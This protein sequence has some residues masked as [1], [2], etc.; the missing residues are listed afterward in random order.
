MTPA[1]VF[2]L[3]LA[4]CWEGPPGELADSTADAS[5][6]ATEPIESDADL[7]TTADTEEAPE[8]FDFDGQRMWDDVNE[9][10]SEAYAGRMPGT[11][12]GELAL[13]F[14]EQHFAAMGLTPLGMNGFRKTFPFDMWLQQGPSV[15]EVE[16]G[17]W[18]EKQDFGLLMGSGAGQVEAALVFAGYGLTVPAFDAASYPTCPL[19]AEGYDDYAGLDVEGKIV[20]V[21]RHGPGGDDAVHEGCPA[22]AAAK[23]FTKAL[24]S[25]GY[26]A[27][28]AALHGAAAVLIVNRFGTPESTPIQGTVGPEYHDPQ[29]IVASVHRQKVA[30]ALPE[31][32][33]WQA[34]IDKNLAPASTDTGLQLVLEAQAGVEARETDNL[35]A[36]FPGTDPELSKEAVV[37]GAHIDHLGVDPVTGELYA[38]ADDNA[39]G[40]SVLMELAR[41]LRAGLIEPRR[42]VVLA[43]FNAEEQGLLGSCEYVRRPSH[44]IASTKAMF[45]LDMVG[46]GDG[47]G[48]VLYGADGKTFPE[49][50]DL[51]RSSAEASGVVG[52]VVQGPALDASDHYCFALAGVP[53]VLVSSSGLHKTYHTPK[54]TADAILPSVLETSARLS[55]AALSA[56]VMD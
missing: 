49:L 34:S 46:L 15:L 24:W 48:V 20:L 39:S 14:V 6:A 45:S 38:G 22:N 28:N 9:L 17:S 4:A 32:A 1:V 31:L 36:S 51:M 29:V 47:A 43:S 13:R 23:T 18:V 42:T 27:A 30:A 41:A 56:L 19:P 16:G 40:T 2:L 55:W 26:K 10:T 44:P 12:G 53:A 7:E 54:D 8:P 35:L 33:T 37:F 21:F 50:G 5:D 11:P 52:T 3:S 25:F